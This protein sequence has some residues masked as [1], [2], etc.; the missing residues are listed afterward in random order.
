[1]T[2]VDRINAALYL[3]RDVRDMVQSYLGPAC[4]SRSV[5]RLVSDL[6]NEGC[7]G[8]LVGWFVHA[9]LECGRLE[10][11][12]PGLPLPPSDDQ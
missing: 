7:P 1:M 2:R 12:P 9:Y 11:D 6:V 10:F 5:S 8:H 4:W 3:P